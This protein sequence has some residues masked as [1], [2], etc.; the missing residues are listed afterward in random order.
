MHFSG[1]LPF[2]TEEFYLDKIRPF[3]KINP[4]QLFYERKYFLLLLFVDFTIFLSGFSLFKKK[5]SE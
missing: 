2:N 3:N 5:N 1:S 4:G